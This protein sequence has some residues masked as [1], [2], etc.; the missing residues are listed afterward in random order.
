MRIYD[1]KTYRDM[2][3]GEFTK[4]EAARKK[5]ELEEKA[6]PLTAEEVNRLFITQN[7]NALLVDDNTAL[8]MVEF[9]P[10][11]TPGTAYTVGFMV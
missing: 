9:Y 5:F 8:R 6:R 2:T 11:W 1:G 4:A 3:P 10:E 7:I